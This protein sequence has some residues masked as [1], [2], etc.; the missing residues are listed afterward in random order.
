ME[1]KTHY[2][3]AF[4]YND[5]PAELGEP[6]GFWQFESYQKLWQ[7]FEMSEV[8]NKTFD[9]LGEPTYSRIAI[10]TDD[11]G[12]VLFHLLILSAKYISA[13]RAGEAVDLAKAW[14]RERGKK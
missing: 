4:G 2:L 7:A 10:A 6:S 11:E 9:T 8:M 13:S 12:Y 5:S 1:R 3:G 14:V